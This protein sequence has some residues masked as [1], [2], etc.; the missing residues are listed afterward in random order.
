MVL[1]AAVSDGART[2]LGGDKSRR[3]SSTGA[4]PGGGGGSA[5]PSPRGRTGPGRAPPDGYRG[6]GRGWAPGL[7]G[8]GPRRSWA[9]AG[10]TGRACGLRLVRGGVEGPGWLGGE[11]R[12]ALGGWAKA[13]EADRSLGG[14]GACSLP[15]GRRGPLLSEGGG[16]ACI[17][18]CGA[19]SFH[20]HAAWDYIPNPPRRSPF[21]GGLGGGG[22]A[23][24]ACTHPC[25]GGGGRRWEL[26]PAWPKKNPVASPR[27]VGPLEEE[28]RIRRGGLRYMAWCGMVWYG[29]VWYGM[30]WYGMVWYGMVCCCCC[31]CC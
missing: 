26:R 15:G 25:G 28:P 2:L 29:M 1:G 24:V 8:P 9:G 3:A 4:N 7:W 30:V 6:G 14:G 17:A 16:R 13:P 11:P 19:M 27:L 10:E 31:C 12:E 5:A 22:L 18:R 23:V 21:L 20:G